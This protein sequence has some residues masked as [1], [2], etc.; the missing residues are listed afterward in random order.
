MIFTINYMILAY[1][2][3]FFLLVILYTVSAH[4]QKLI[5]ARSS[6]VRFGKPSAIWRWPLLLG[7]LI[8]VF[9]VGLRYDVGVDY[10]G[11]RYDFEGIVNNEGQ[12]E[13][14]E[15]GY[16][17]VGYGLSILGLGAWS[18]FMFTAFITWYYFIRS[19]E[20]FPFLLKWGFLFA[21]TTGFLFASMNGMRQTMALVI[22]M[23]AVKF[24][25]E[26]SL[27]KYTLFMLLAFSFHTS[28]VLV[29]PVYFFINKISFS[30]NKWTLLYVVTFILGD[31]IDIR[32]MVVYGAALIPKYQHYVTRFLED[33]E[34]PLTLGPGGI[35]FFLVGLLVIV[36]SKDF[37]KR[38]PKLTIYYNLYYIGAILYNFFWKFEILGR[39]YYL[40][41]WFEIFCLAAI[42]YYLGKSN[43]RLVLYLLLITQVLIFV[44]KIYKGENQCAP[45]QFV[46]MG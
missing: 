7:L 28:I 17:V 27:L 10:L 35:Y 45:F 4:N 32:K 42:A 24:I 6:L 31:S 12:W 19:F 25:E 23:Y 33:F 29:Y 41:I 37:L 20:V 8:L 34:A 38:N 14:Y 22:F 21:M 26:R 16:K 40:F 30:G 39:V 5:I 44:Y 13:R 46:G 15:F 9:I 18:L 43:N 1:C 2:I 36:L 3:Y 11:Y